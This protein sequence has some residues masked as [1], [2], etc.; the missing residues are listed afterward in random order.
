MIFV[1]FEDLPFAGHEYKKD[2]IMRFVDYIPSIYK[3]DGAV[4]GF[5]GSY[6]TSG[7]MMP[8]S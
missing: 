3:N 8:S 6:V 7:P 5:E 2:R 4:F 1:F